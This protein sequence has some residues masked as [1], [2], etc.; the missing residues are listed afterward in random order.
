M[1]QKF[2]RV[3]VADCSIN[4]LTHLWEQLHKLMDVRIMNHHSGHKPYYFQKN[5]LKELDVVFIDADGLGHESCYYSEHIQ[6]EFPYVKIIWCFI[7]DDPDNHFHACRLGASGFLL[8]NCSEKE[9]KSKFA[10]LGLIIEKKRDKKT[11]SGHPFQHLKG[12][13]QPLPVHRNNRLPL[14]GTEEQHMICYLCLQK[15]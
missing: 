6:N 4:G 5:D 12:I 15:Q 2:I 7:H 8:S 10:L 3:G 13:K 14:C 11:T 9:L 1:S